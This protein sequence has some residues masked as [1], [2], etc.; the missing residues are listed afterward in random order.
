MLCEINQRC[1]NNNNNDTHTYSIIGAEELEV[2]ISLL[3]KR[4]K[5]KDALGQLDRLS[6]R[7]P[8]QS[9]TDEHSFSADGSLVKI[10]S[11]QLANLRIKLLQELLTI[12]ATDREHSLQT[13]KE[14]SAEN[15][16]FDSTEHSAE[17][18]RL[19]TEERSYRSEFI[20]EL[21]KILKGY[22]DQWEAHVLLIKILLTPLP[23]PLPLPQSKSTSKSTPV[24]T[25][26][27]PSLSLSD[28][29]SNESE[30]KSESQSESESES[31]Y[32]LLAEHHLYLAS[33]QETQGIL[34]GSFLAEMLLLAAAAH[35]HAH[36]SNATSTSIN[37]TTNTGITKENKGK[38]ND[39]DND[40]N[41]NNVLE[42][43][44]QGLLDDVLP[45]WW[46]NS[47]SSTTVSLPFLPLI[48][49][50]ET[51]I[52]EL[53]V[54]LLQYINRFQGKQCCFSDIKPFLGLISR[55][56]STGEKSEGE[57]KREKKKEKQGEQKEGEKGG[58]K[59]EEGSSRGTVRTVAVRALEGLRDAVYAQQVQTIGR[60]MLMAN[61][62]DTHTQEAQ[63]P[64]VEKEKEKEVVDVIA[65]QSSLVSD[66]KLETV[67]VI[68]TETETETVITRAV[69]NE[70]EILTE[71]ETDTILATAIIVGEEGEE[72]EGG[73]GEVK[74]N[75]KSKKK[76]KKEKEKGKESNE[77]DSISD[78]LTS[79]DTESSASKSSSS[80][81]ANAVLNN[82]SKAV[83]TT[84]GVGGGVGRGVTGKE[85]KSK[86]DGKSG[87]KSEK[88]SSEKSE[89]DKRR[90]RAGVALCSTSKLG[91]I[92]QY[93]DYLLLNLHTQSP[94]HH[95]HSNGGHNV[96]AEEK[97]EKKEEEKDEDEVFLSKMMSLFSTTRHLC[98]GGVGGDKEVP[99]K[100]TLYTHTHT[101]THTHSL[102][103]LTSISRTSPSLSSLL[104]T[105]PSLSS[106][107]PFFPLFFSPHPISPFLSFHFFYL[108]PLHFTPPHLSPFL[109]FSLL[110]SPSLFSS[111]LTVSSSLSFTH[112]SFPLLSTTSPHFY[113]F[114][115]LLTSLL[116]SPH[117]TSLH[118]LPPPSLSITHLSGP[119]RR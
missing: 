53:C 74:K 83:A 22:P 109:S 69:T 47:R 91:Q 119:S 9:L 13:F 110:I 112:L 8:G 61:N 32:S 68:E 92:K 14:R 36:A 51:I 86:S 65:S 71:M 87:S 67:S 117:L 46:T 31:Q 116:S 45:L 84:G 25:T 37:T 66:P 114:S 115:P 5:V 23:L 118:L 78:K 10:H 96:I 7:P 99:H 56:V 40:G 44:F 63:V 6:R 16:S 59:G 80:D 52:S 85:G 108:S 12:N 113:L 58:E 18:S 57:A 75:K 4:G 105:S 42:S 49:G 48:E 35:A 1:N 3:L 60:L 21:K 50:R 29:Q 28:K 103:S 100:H 41:D 70:I 64:V 90:E 15:A 24:S 98:L 62:D 17:H 39:N 79:K 77:L 93:C 20:A 89:E 19:L 72:V 55:S 101:H 94:S 107:H 76:K 33:L 88:K 81:A 26:V 104:L 38:S 54:L 43:E 30:S 111:L 82:E 11:L 27:S 95:I 34:R 2:Y 102:F 73:G 97:E 106:T